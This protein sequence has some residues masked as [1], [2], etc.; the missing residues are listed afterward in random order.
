MAEHQSPR[1]G[2][3]NCNEIEKTTMSKNIDVYFSKD[4]AVEMSEVPW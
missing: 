2:D 4:M 1:F 3:N